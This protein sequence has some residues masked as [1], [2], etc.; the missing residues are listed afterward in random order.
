MGIKPIFQNAEFHNFQAQFDPQEETHTLTLWKGIADSSVVASE[1]I[2]ELLGLIMSWT[3][4]T[5]S[6]NQ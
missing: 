1:V 6:Q 2:M 3:C 5:P 4:K